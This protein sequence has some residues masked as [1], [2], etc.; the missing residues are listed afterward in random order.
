MGTEEHSVNA[1]TMPSHLFRRAPVDGGSPLGGN[2]P[3]I[4]YRLVSDDEGAVTGT[5]QSDQRLHR[6]GEKPELTPALHVVRPVAVDHAISIAA[7][8][9]H[10]QHPLR[11]QCPL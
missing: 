3:A 7:G 10:G 8:I 11:D 5:G 2:D 6:A 1:A 4:D 9:Q